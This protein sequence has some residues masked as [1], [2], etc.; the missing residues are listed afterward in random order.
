MIW[1][2]VGRNPVLFYQRSDFHR[3]NNLSIADHVCIKRKKTS[4]LYDIFQNQLLCQCTKVVN[5]NHID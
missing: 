1:L 5:I 3:N 4:I 2:Q